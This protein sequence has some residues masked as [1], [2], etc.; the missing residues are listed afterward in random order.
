VKIP[1]EGWL[2]DSV[3]IAGE[4][5]VLVPGG[6]P[7]HPGYLAFEVTGAADSGSGSVPVV[8]TVTGPANVTSNTI[9]NLEIKS[10]AVDTPTDSELTTLNNSAEATQTVALTITDRT[11]GTDDVSFVG[12][13]LGGYEDGKGTQQGQTDADPLNQLLSLTFN[14]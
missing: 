13:G 6:L 3:T 4:A 10:L 7:S 11:G 8:I 5:G 1:A 9:E 2:I 12:S 14:L